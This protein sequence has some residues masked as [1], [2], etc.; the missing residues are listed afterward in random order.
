[1]LQWMNASSLIAANIAEAMFSE[2]SQKPQ[3]KKIWQSNKI[4]I[5]VKGYLTL[6]SPQLCIAPPELIDSGV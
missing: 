6:P 2:Y 5:T 3:S 4:I 1:M